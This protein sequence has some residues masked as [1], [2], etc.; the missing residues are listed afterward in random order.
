MIILGIDTST[1]ISEVTILENNQII[2]DFSMNQEKTHSESLVPL[3]ERA[4]ESQSLKMEDIDV[5]GIS[6]GPGSFTGLRI[7]LTVAKT[8]AQFLDLKIIGISTLDALQRGIYQKDRLIVPLI[9][10]RGKKV[11]YGGYVNNE[12]VIKEG[13]IDI[14]DLVEGMKDKNPIF[15]GDITNKYKEELSE[16]GEIAPI[17]FNNCIGKNICEIARLRAIDEDFDDLYD[18]SP[19]YLR[20]SQAEIDYIKKNTKVN[21]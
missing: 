16:V 14:K 6:I 21:K 9:D 17:N 18:L 3:I 1:M 15:V 2:V 5:I 13:M 4:V 19:N 10:A 20:K 8:L 12:E 11:F 7:G